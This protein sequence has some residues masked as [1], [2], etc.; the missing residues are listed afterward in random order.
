MAGG[1][2]RVLM[3]KEPKLAVEFRLPAAE[4]DRALEKALRHNSKKFGG[5]GG[6]I[7]VDKARLACAAM[8]VLISFVPAT[9]HGGAGLVETVTL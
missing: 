1:F 4:L 3:V 2:G 7:R 5:T 8:I 6:S 9:L